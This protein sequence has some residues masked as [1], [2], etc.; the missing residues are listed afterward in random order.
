MSTDQQRELTGSAESPMPDSQILVRAYET[1]DPTEPETL[2]AT[3]LHISE[4]E[5]LE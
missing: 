3:G 4:A 5:I 2:W 1:V